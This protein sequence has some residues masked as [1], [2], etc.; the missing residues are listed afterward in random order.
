[1][2]QASTNAPAKAQP[3]PA[4]PPARWKEREFLGGLRDEVERV[5][6]DFDRGMWGLPARWRG[7]AMEPFG[8]AGPWR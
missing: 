1:M 5:F 2:A 4:Q 8:K 7:P 3:K 6:E